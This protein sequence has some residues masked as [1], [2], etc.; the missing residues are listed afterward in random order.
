MFHRQLVILEK[1]QRDKPLTRSIIW[2]PSYIDGLQDCGNSI[3]NALEFMQSCAKPSI[4]VYSGW[5]YS[6]GCYFSNYI[7]NLTTEVFKLCSESSVRR[8]DCSHQFYLICFAPF[9]CNDILSIEVFHI[10]AT[11]SRKVLWT[12]IYHILSDWLFLLQ[13]SN[14][15]YGLPY[16]TWT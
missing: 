8:W 3:T 11:W 1:L 14:M 4:Y 12:A 9:Y 5:C 7:L 15:F 16:D 13:N 10:N 2:W 6:K